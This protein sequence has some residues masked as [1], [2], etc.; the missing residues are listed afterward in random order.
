MVELEEELNLLH[1]SQD[2]NIAKAKK[3]VHR[4]L[5]GLYRARLENACQILRRQR[6]DRARRAASSSRM[7]PHLTRG[8]D[9]FFRM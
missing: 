1:L 9:L 4:E 8:M 5:D 3:E 7:A 2:D 6:G